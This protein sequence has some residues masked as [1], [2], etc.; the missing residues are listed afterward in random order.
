[1]NQRSAFVWTAETGAELTE[2]ARALDAKHAGEGLAVREKAHAFATAAG[3]TLVDRTESALAGL[4]EL[5]ARYK[6]LA[7]VERTAR[8]EAWFTEVDAPPQLRGCAVIQAAKPIACLVS[9][10]GAALLIPSASAFT[11]EAFDTLR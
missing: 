10:R 5:R 7:Y 4:F 1:M 2:L 6:T 8:T 11:Q 9:S 3:L